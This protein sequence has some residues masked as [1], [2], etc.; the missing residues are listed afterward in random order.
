MQKPI[1][2]ALLAAASLYAHSAMAQSADCTEITALPATIA[3]AGKYCLAQDFTVNSTS[4]K[5]ITIDANDVELDC[6]G[7]T[8]RNLAM[9]DHGTSEGIFSYDRNSISVRN[10][11]I[12]GGFTNGISLLQNNNN[13]TRTYYITVEDNL[14]AGPYWHGIR[15]YGSAVEIRDNRIYDIGGQLDN[16]AMGIR[17]AGSV[18]GGSPKFHLVHGNVVAGT[19]SPYK[20]AFGIYSENSVASLYWMNEV[21]GT[22]ASNQGFRSYAFRIGGSVNSVRD[23]NIVGSPLA[24]DTGIYATTGSTDCYDNHIRSPQPTTGCDATMGN[25]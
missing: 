5:A 22:T 19:N 12:Q 25:Y 14:V 6:R 1:V 11:K 15:V 3:D 9:S 2:A 23:N 4:I 17:V 21:T 18:A 7:H 8:I 20:Q 13:P 24:N 10:C 16:Y